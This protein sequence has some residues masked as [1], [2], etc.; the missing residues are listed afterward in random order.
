MRKKLFILM[1]VFY[2]LILLLVVRDLYSFIFVTAVLGFF[3]L[4]LF[5][6]DI[7]KKT[8]FSVKNRLLVS[9]FLQGIV[10]VVLLLILS[11]MLIYVMFTGFSSTLLLGWLDYKIAELE[12]GEGLP[13]NLPLKDG[14]EGLVIDG[15]KVFIA[16]KKEN[17]RI[18][19]IDLVLPEFFREEYGLEVYIP[20]YIYY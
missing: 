3:L 18:S 11:M 5:S 1:V 14:F 12:N 7:L 8:F 20:P 13:F 6:P 15:D 9:Y 17:V 4:V 10:P 16:V 2:F 19:R